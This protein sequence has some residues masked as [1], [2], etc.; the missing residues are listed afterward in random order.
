[1]PIRVA[2]VGVVA[3]ATISG[4]P[5]VADHALVLRGLRALLRAQA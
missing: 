1:V 3:V 5:D 2:G 4:L